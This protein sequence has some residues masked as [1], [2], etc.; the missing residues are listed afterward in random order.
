LQEKLL[1]EKFNY[2]NWGT[3]AN[4]AFL[5]GKHLTGKTISSIKEGELERAHSDGQGALSQVSAST[6]S[7]RQACEW[8][9][10]PVSRF[11]FFKVLNLLLVS[12]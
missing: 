4:T 7:L 3:I 11:A 5:V 2:P 9:V 1:D 10:G 6:T 12:F 8:R